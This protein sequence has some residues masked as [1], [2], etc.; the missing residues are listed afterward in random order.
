[1]TVSSALSN[2][3]FSGNGTQTAF[4]FN[5]VNYNSI[6]AFAVMYTDA[7]GI[8][9]LLP[10]ASYTLTINSPATG[11]TWGIGG[12]LTVS[13]AIANGTT[14]TIQRI[15]P[16]LQTSSLSNQ[17]TLYQQTIETIVDT[18][19]MQLQQIAARTGQWRGVWQTSTQYNYGD[20]VQDGANGA[21]TGNYYFCTNTN[22]SGYWA[23]D[24]ANGYWV[25]YLNIQQVSGYATDAAAS[26]SA[27]AVG[28]STAISEANA[29]TIAAGN[30]LTYSNAASTAATTA[31]TEAGIATTQAT[32][33]S[34]SAA[35]AST[36]ATTATTQA[37]IATSAATTATTQATAATTEAVI[38]T[39]QAAAA[40][41]SAMAAAGTITATS[42]TS[43]TIG[44]GSF[45]F[46]TQANKNFFPGQFIVA[47]SNANGANYIHGQ[48]TSYSGT[49]LVMTESDNGGSGT[50][51]DWNISA[52]GPQGASGSGAGTVTTVSVA[53]ANGF[54]G[55]VSNPTTTPAITVST[56]I[57][58]VLK[59]NGTAISQATAGTDYV[60]P[61]G[62]LGTPSSG[63]GTNLTGTASGMTAGAVTGLSVT[64]GKTLTA[65]NSIAL[66]GTD[67]TTMTF[68]AASDTVVTTAATQTISNKTF[69]APALGTPASCVGTNLTGTAAGLTAGAVTTING[70]ISAGSNITLTGSGTA[71]SPYTIAA[72]AN[73]AT[74]I[75][76]Q[77]FTAGG[78]YTPTAGLIFASVAA[79]AGGGAGASANN[80]GSTFNG[81]NGGQTSFGSLVVVNGGTG[82]VAVTSLGSNGGAG[83]TVGSGGATYGGADYAGSGGGGG[84]ASGAGGAGFSGGGGGASGTQLGAAGGFAGGNGGA[85]GG[86]G[87]TGAG[88][89]MT[90]SP[91]NVSTTIPSPPVGFNG[92]GW[93]PT[94]GGG[95]FTGGGGGGGGNGSGG[96]GSGGGGGGGGINNLSHITMGG[97]GG[98]SSGS[99]SAGTV[100]IYG[101][102]GGGGGG[103][104]QGGGGGGGG[105]YSFAA[106][107]PAATI[108][109]SQTIT[110]GA[111]GTA[112]SAGTFKGAAGGAGCVVVI[113]YCS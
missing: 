90:G 20:I 89:G 80:S 63:V 104:T 85:A 46:T 15:I 9:A 65:T 28:A 68:P 25:V 64:S 55:T 106:T 70:K 66:V 52:S 91:G 56:S 79:Q 35:T 6:Y 39:T 54:A 58:G 41:A 78:T 61:G 72:A 50:H 105:G 31:T 40:A 94:Q 75:N 36:A 108:G 96:T 2:Q 19:C 11:Q 87:G 59:G 67:N 113:E 103:G 30:A 83:G 13:P 21:N 24:L 22:L 84:S 82:A 34:V 57:S 111:A 16:F 7:D 38:A 51:A 92:G 81:G 73:G 26:A 93:I 47:A 71:V 107:I 37:G 109:A 8:S 86:A 88:G 97:S 74:K 99:P 23:T 49:T 1:M 14:L 48:V 29:A 33:A 101:G 110:I 42:T 18:I 77:T 69:V 10:P 45:T 100:G 32:N 76:I 4:P 53:S 62:A 27:A 112:P 44:T 5:I 60:A 102:G 98:V 12:T 3:T 43:N 17:G 95:P